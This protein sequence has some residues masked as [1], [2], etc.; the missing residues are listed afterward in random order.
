MRTLWL[1]LASAGVLTSCFGDPPPDPS[2][3][4]LEVVHGSRQ[5]PTEPC[6]LNRYEVGAGTH[7]LVL[8]AEGQP[9]TVS[10]RDSSGSVVYRTEASRGDGEVVPGSVEL[11]AGTYVVECTA[12]ETSSEATLVVTP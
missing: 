5:Q 9:V 2:V 1:V 11:G 10:L 6:L 12:G 4:P 7:E 8:I 3:A